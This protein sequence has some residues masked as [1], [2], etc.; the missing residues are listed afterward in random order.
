ML[1]TQVTE[2]SLHAPLHALKMAPLPACA[3]SVTEAPLAKSAAHVAGHVIAAGALV[4]A[5]DAEP[6]T[7]T[8][9]ENVGP[10]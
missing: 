2:A 4:T 6:L 10:G 8:V 5:P 1:T 7:E 9:S 3:V